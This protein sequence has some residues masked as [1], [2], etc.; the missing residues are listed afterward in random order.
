MS[1]LQQ[2][3]IVE[4][5]L[6]LIKCYFTEI[7]ESYINNNSYSSWELVKHSIP[8]GSILGPLFFLLFINDLPI[9][10][11]DNAKLVLYADDTSIIITSHSTTEFSTKVNTVFADVN[12]LV[13]LKL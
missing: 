3:G 10:T 11:S 5:F 1:K 2:Y 6:A 13:V 12:E 4:K 9:I 8:Q 7:P